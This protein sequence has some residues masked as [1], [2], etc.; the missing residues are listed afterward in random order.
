M[1]ALQLLLRYYLFSTLVALAVCAPGTQAQMVGG[2]ISGDVVD[3]GGAAVASAE[4]LILNEE[5]CTE[6]KF[7]TADSGTFSA[8]SVAVGVRVDPLP[9]EG[10]NPFAG[11]GPLDRMGAQSQPPYRDAIAGPERDLKT[12]PLGHVTTPHIGEKPEGVILSIIAM[13]QSAHLDLGPQ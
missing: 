9:A 7:I 13:R 12:F 1:R 3:P 8:P 10:D 2:T 4:V 11:S 5:T 6:R